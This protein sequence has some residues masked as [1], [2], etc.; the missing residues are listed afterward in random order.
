MPTSPKCSACDAPMMWATSE[1][2]GRPMPLDAE[3]VVAKAGEPALELRRG[4]F[5]IVRG[6]A[7]AYSAEDARLKRDGFTSHFATC[8][9]AADFHRGR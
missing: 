5:A 3:P 2:T 1:V 6:K 4:V 7:H 8:P 9:R